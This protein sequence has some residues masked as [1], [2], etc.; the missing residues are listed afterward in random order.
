MYIN[1]V[2]W[3]MIESRYSKLQSAK[4]EDMKA[5]EEETIKWQNTIVMPFPKSIVLEKIVVSPVSVA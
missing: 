2:S 1:S 3:E 5:W 4:S